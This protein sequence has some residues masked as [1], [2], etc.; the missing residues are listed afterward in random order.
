MKINKI[1]LLMVLSTT[2]FSQDKIVSNFN[3]FGNISASKLNTQGFDL[4]NYNHDSVSKTL[5]FSPYSKL[6]AQ[7]SVNYNDITFTAQ[8]L[9][10]EERDEYKPELTWFNLKYDINDNYS[11][12]VGRIQTKAFLH[13]ES[14]DL[15]YLHLWTKP[16]VEVYRLMPVRT[17]NGIEFTYDTTF[18]RYSLNISIAPF[19]YYESN[20]YGTKNTKTSLELDNSYAASV[21]LESEKILYKISYSKSDTDIPDDT[22]MQMIVAGL[23]AYGN[24]MDR[25]TYRN[26]AAYSSSLGLQYR[27]DTIFIDTELAYMKSN[28]LLPS[29][30]AAYMIIGY[31]IDKFIPFIMYAKNQNDKNYFD[32]SAISTIDTTSTTLKRALDDSLYLNNYSQSTASIGIKY[33]IDIGL[34]F[35]AQVDRI[36]S[37]NYGS[38]SASGVQA[39]GYEKVGILSRDAGTP[40]KAIYAFT[41][42]VSFAY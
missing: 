3:Y 4:N 23:S 39:S 28:S 12:R 29:S 25:Y 34:A 35:K 26:R 20:I 17:Y 30:R 32:T 37:S 38:I 1:I 18:D 19:G 10:R 31:K 15:D 24:S 14:I 5:S 11:V 8:G 36:I 7:L 2:L 21:T 6:G 41:V 16:P 27:G 33:D 42:G 13:S 22:S 9:L 40:D